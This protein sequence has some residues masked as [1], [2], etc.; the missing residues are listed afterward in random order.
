MLT[1]LLEGK[2]KNF[3]REGDVVVQVSSGDEYTI[4][5]VLGKEG[6]ILTTTGIFLDLTPDIKA[7]EETYKN[8]KVID[9]RIKKRFK[10]D[11]KIRIK[12]FDSEMP[13]M[14]KIVQGDWIDLRSDADVELKAGQ[15]TLI[16][17]GV[18]MEL[19]EGYEAYVIPRSSTYKK[20][21]VIQT[22]SFGLIDESYKGDGDQWFMPV[23]ATM[24]TKISKYDRICQF[25]IQRKM[26]KVEFEEVEILGNEDRGGHGSTGIR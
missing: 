22:N 19:P 1:I 7:T 20:Y 5:K 2:K 24:D 8:R 3:Y 4:E 17:L 18:A 16:P 12:Y 6:K 26:P 13:R 10:K 23:F 11:L 15:F 9:K 14:E 21:F 25:R